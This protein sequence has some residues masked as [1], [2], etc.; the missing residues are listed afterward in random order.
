MQ[1]GTVG[2]AATPGEGFGSRLSSIERNTKIY[3]K[4]PTIIL[5]NMS[6]YIYISFLLFKISIVDKVLFI[7]PLKFNIF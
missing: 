3:F 4:Y 5:H 2:Y 6:I 1:P 7:Y